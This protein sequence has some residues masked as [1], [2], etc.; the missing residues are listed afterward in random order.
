MAETNTCPVI[1]QALDEKSRR[2]YALPTAAW[3]LYPT[4]SKK[5]KP[6]CVACERGLEPLEVNPFRGPPH[7]SPE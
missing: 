6:N 4:A 2:E 1:N 7:A 5:G 3:K